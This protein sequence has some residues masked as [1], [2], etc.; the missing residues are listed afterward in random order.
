MESKMKQFQCETDIWKRSLD[1]MRDENIHLKNR[2]TEILKNGFDKKLLENLE[3]FQTR[4]IK[5]D[6][7]IG[8]IRDDIAA[9]DKIILDN[10]LADDQVV[11]ETNKKLATL[12]NNVLHAEKQFNELK[13][14]FSNYMLKMLSTKNNIVAA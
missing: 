5:E 6:E 11:N 2:L 4:F 8:L 3:Y 9:I 13:L 14:E 12:R 1:F 7:R 10:F